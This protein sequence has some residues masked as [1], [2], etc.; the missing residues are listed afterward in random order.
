MPL[1]HTFDTSTLGWTLREL[2]EHE[3]WERGDK[4]GLCHAPAGLYIVQPDFATRYREGEKVFG[5]SADV[6]DCYRCGAVGTKSYTDEKTDMSAKLVKGQHS[7]LLSRMEMYRSNWVT[8]ARIYAFL[9]VGRRMAGTPFGHRADQLYVKPS[10]RLQVDKQPL[11]VYRENEFHHNLNQSADSAR[12]RGI[13]KVYP[14]AKSEWYAARNVLSLI[15]EL[16][17]LNNLGDV[18]NLYIFEAGRDKATKFSKARVADYVTVTTR[19]YRNDT[20]GLTAVA[21]D[22]ATRAHRSHYA[23]GQGRARNP[24]YVESRR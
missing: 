16:A 8:G 24:N 11:I 4:A 19:R 5:T 15:G 13:K 9:Q 1:Q 10:D 21:R 7:T 22:G 17:K 12:V 6:R 14:A 3:S 18:E 2:K 20:D 23:P